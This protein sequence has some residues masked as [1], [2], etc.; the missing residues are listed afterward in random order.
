[1]DN[2]KGCNLELRMHPYVSMFEH[3]VEFLF[4]A[5]ALARA[6]AQEEKP[7]PAYFVVAFN[8]DLVDAGGS[9]EE[10]ALDADTIA[11]NAADG[12]SGVVPI[13]VGEKYSPFEFLDTFAGAFLDFNMHADRITSCHGGD[14]GVYGSINGFH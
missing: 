14:I 12:E 7:S 10:C 1:M 11:G 4:E 8:H 5:C 6:V 2:K 13:V 9:V 3:L